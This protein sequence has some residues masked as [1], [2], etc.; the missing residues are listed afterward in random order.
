MYLDMPTPAPKTKTKVRH[1]YAFT[2][3]LMRQA[4]DLLP[5][6]FSSKRRKEYAT[7]FARFQK[8]PSTPYPEIQE[9]IAELGKESWP[10]RKAFEDLYARYGRASEES[11]LL[12]HLDQG[13]RDKY[14][15]FINEGGKLNHILE[16]KS[17]TEIWVA[18]RFERFF[19]PEE[20]FSIGQALIEARRAARQEIEEL[21]KG[22]RRAEYEALISKYDKRRG[23]MTDKLHELRKLAGVSPKWQPEIEGQ[24][25]TFEEG[26]SVVEKQLDESEL[27]KLI[28]YWKGTLDAFLAA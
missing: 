22:P 9:T 13:L 5:P 16:A 21:I 6:G 1:P 15:T 8:S 17:G 23:V 18:S 20:K 24:I 2:L 25:Q 28:E 11:Q 10:Y 7:A 12:T 27:D 14:E 19:A 3:D 26:W 4:I